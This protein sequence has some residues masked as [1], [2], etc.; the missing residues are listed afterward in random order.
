M[1]GPSGQ[2]GKEA[3]PSLAGKARDLLYGGGGSGGS[4]PVGEEFRSAPLVAAGRVRV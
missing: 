2:R 1:W 3:R 4:K